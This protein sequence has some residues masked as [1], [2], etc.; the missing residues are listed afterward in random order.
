VIGL[1][2]SGYLS[3]FNGTVPINNL[4]VGDGGANGYIRIKTNTNQ[5]LIASYLNNTTQLSQDIIFTDYNGNPLAKIDTGSNI[6]AYNNLQARNSILTSN[7]TSDSVTANTITVD[8]LTA[9]N[10]IMSGITTSIN[11][12]TGSNITALSNIIGGHDLTI[13]RHITATT[14]NI[15][16]L[17]G[18]ITAGGSI[19]ATGNVTGA[20]VIATSDFRLKTNIVT[21]DSPLEKISAMRGVYF[22]KISDSTIRKVGVIAQEI[23]TVLPEVVFTEDTEE[24]M[25]GVSYGNIASILIEGIKAQQSSIQSL[26]TT[27]SSIQ[28]QILLL[29]R[30]TP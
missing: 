30:P 1:G 10:I 25:K 13:Y 18:N 21:I 5:S 22:H 8:T 9:G 2:S 7:F 11:D 19:T 15:A 6:Y 26:V 14:G 12:I 24:K 20:D 23:E 29:Q 17:A 4:I 16:A 27:I 28:S 3:S